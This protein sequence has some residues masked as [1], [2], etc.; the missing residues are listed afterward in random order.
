MS[1][2]F[3]ANGVV[4]SL[5]GGATYSAVR[6]IDSSMGQ[7]NHSMLNPGD[8][9][10]L[11]NSSRHGGRML[12]AAWGQAID[13]KEQAGIPQKAVY[14]DDDLHSFRYSDAVPAAVAGEA[15]LAQVSGETVVVAMRGSGPPPATSAACGCAGCSCIATALSTDSG[16]TWSPSVLNPTLPS[17]GVASGI[18]RVRTTRTVRVLCFGSAHAHTAAV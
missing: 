15:A 17:P 14:S 12:W 5:D 13:G 2:T 9:I 7:A 1:C 3:Q 8:G 16:V 11:D 18:I 10:V 4:T 6:W